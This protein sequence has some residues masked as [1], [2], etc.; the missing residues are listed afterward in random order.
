MYNLYNPLIQKIEV[1]KLEKR[2]DEE[3]YYLRD[4]LPEYSTIPFNMESVPLPPGAEVP[5][6]RIKVKL[7]PPPWSKRWELSN[8]KGLACVWDVLSEQRK[9]TLI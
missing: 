2:L 9:D 3:L 1:L 7:R 4:A 6:N 8:C 5:L